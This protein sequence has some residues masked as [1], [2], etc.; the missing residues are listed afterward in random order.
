MDALSS[1]GNS[2]FNFEQ[3]Q[4]LEKM[5]LNLLG[6]TGESADDARKVHFN[7][8]CGIG[9]NLATIP[10]TSDALYQ[11]TGKMQYIHV[12]GS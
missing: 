10:C 8:S 11:H 5:Y 7:R 12:I 6:K 2:L 3:F 4:I 9:I 1:L